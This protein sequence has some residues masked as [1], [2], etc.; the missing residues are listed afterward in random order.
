MRCKVPKGI[1]SVACTVI[2]IQLNRLGTCPRRAD[3]LLAV[4]CYISASVSAANCTVFVRMGRCF[5]RR[6]SEWAMSFLKTLPM[7]WSSSS[8]K[9][10]KMPSVSRLFNEL[11]VSG[12]ERMRCRFRLLLG[13]PRWS[14]NCLSS[15][16]SWSFTRRIAIGLPGEKDP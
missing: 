3:G 2:R 14:R 7:I 6:I 1:S 9:A 12:G 13:M 11:S 8:S 5:R 10:G 4:L 15:S 16:N